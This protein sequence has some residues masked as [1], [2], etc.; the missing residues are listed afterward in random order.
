MI[1][2]EVAPFTPFCANLLTRTIAPT[3]VPIRLTTPSR[4]FPIVAKSKVPK[5]LR[6]FDKITIAEEMIT[7]EVAPFTPS[8]ANL[9]RSTIAPTNVPINPSTPSNPLPSSVR[10]NELISIKTLERIFNAAAKIT[11]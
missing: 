3:S 5:S 11:I 8:C 1:T 4:P 2:I 10:F 9:L 7:I 6:T